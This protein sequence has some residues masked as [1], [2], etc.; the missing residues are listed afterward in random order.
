MGVKKPGDA[1]HSLALVW[2]SADPLGPCVP[3]GAAYLIKRTAP[4]MLTDTVV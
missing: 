4:D 2:L 3:T 1:R